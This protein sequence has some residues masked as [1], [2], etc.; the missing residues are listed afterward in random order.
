MATKK[1]KGKKKAVKVLPVGRPSEFTKE[2][3][4]Y[5]CEKIST[6]EVGIRTLHEQDSKF[7]SMS[8]IMRWLKNHSEFR[9]QY[10]RAKEAQADMFF[11]QIVEIANTPVLG[12]TKKSGVNQFGDFEEVTE[13]DA[14]AH[15]RLQV[16]ARK[17][18]ISK[19]NPKKFGDKV[20]ITT[21]GEKLPQTII[22]WGDKKI[23]V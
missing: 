5:I 23:Q 22:T 20:D 18:V 13:A 1:A 11:E 8:T 12:V 9:D 21:G 14:I 4:D 7:P 16:D 2:I 10:A 6:S 19:L 15:R 17:W 3:G